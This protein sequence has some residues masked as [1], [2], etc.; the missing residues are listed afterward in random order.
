MTP[1]RRRAEAIAAAALLLA[2]AS[3]KVVGENL[4]GFLDLALAAAV[5]LALRAAL[6]GRRATQPEDAAPRRRLP[7]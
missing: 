2:W 4:L 3:G 5:F 6:A 7:R 1:G